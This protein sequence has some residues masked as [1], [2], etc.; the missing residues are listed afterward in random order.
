MSNNLH[1]SLFDLSSIHQ[2][3]WKDFCD[4]CYSRFGFEQGE[5]R[6]YEQKYETFCRCI[7]SDILEGKAEKYWLEVEYPEGWEVDKDE[8]VLEQRQKCEPTTPNP[9]VDAIR[10]QTQAMKQTAE[11]MMKVAAKPTSIGQLNMGNGEQTLP[12]STNIPLIP[13]Q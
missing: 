13:E 7:I 8:L 3:Y 10:E 12:P 11:A 9:I 5:V 1:T 4:V 6:T 2:K